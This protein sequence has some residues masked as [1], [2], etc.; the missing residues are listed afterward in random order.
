LVNGNKSIPG[1]SILGNRP[2]GDYKVKMIGITKSGKL[3][4][5]ETSTHMTLWT[6]AKV[7]QGIRY[8]IIYEFNESK[9]ISIY[10]KYLTEIVTP[11]IPVGA[12][13]IIKGHTDIIGEE[14]YNQDL[15]L[16][17][18]NNVKSIIQNSLEKSGRTDVKFVI[19]GFGED[20]KS[21]PFENKYPEERSY[22]RTVI[23]DIVPA[24]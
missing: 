20:Q 1:K 8:S 16:A 24:N 4:E 7:E 9:A 21:A 2:E 10:E 13:V 19:N 22:N 23:I 6:P 11:N 15:S 12:T 17:R 3:S 14:V 18:A 5:K